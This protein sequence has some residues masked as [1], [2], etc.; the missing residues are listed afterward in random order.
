MW[1]LTT[2]HAVWVRPVPYACAC[3]GC[4]CPAFGRRMFNSVHPSNSLPK[5][6]STASG[7]T[8]TVLH[9]CCAAGQGARGVHHEPNATRGRTTSCRSE[10]GRRRWR[11]CCCLSL[12]S[13]AVQ[14]CS[15]SAECRR[16]GVLTAC[17]QG[18]KRADA[19]CHE[20]HTAGQ[21]D[22]R[23]QSP[24][25]SFLTG[26]ATRRHHPPGLRPLV[27]HYGGVGRPPPPA[28]GWGATHVR[29]LALCEGGLAGAPLEA[30]RA[31]G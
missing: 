20:P 12:D 10:C 24:R 5:D 26:A 19:S 15:R 7:N 23:R 8:V 4:I 3:S 21:C 27:T 2:L 11:Y 29:R 25:R 22:G 16:P 9:G 31:G 17:A 6:T 13:H 18:A 1:R 30:G 28:T 14:E